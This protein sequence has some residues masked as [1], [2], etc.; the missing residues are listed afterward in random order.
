MGE[1]PG[2]LGPQ[3]LLL[4]HTTTKKTHFK[5]T[6]FSTFWSSHHIEYSSIS[7]SESLKYVLKYTQKKKKKSHRQDFYNQQPLTPTNKLKTPIFI[8]ILLCYLFNKHPIIAVTFSISPQVKR[9]SALVYYKRTVI[10]MKNTKK[11]K[12]HSPGAQT[13]HLVSFG[14]ILFASP[15]LLSMFHIFCSFRPIY[16]WLVAAGSGVVSS[17]VV[18]QCCSLV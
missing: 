12:R 9:G 6:T 4:I 16:V 10:I 17:R 7:S 14:P 3:C 1:K 8:T 11:K 18:V 15:F 2:P 5:Q 13:T